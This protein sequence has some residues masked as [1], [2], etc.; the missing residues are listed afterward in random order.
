MSLFDQI[1]KENGI[2]TE[3]TI[4]RYDDTPKNSFKID[5]NT[6][7]GSTG[8]GA[9]YFKFYDNT[10]G[11]ARI[12][13]TEPNYPIDH[14]NRKGLHN[15][16]LSNK[17]KRDLMAVL[18]SKPAKLSYS[19]FNTWFEAIAYTANIVAHVSID[20]IEKYKDYPL[21]NCQ[22]YVIPYHMPIP[23]YMKL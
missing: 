15:I 20:D 19:R 1:I 12:L 16:K 6:T 14:A 2:I 13:V 9:S 3:E 18:A 21:Y 10:N 8:I 23:D 5:V 4:V 11:I 22:Q 7:S 17:Q